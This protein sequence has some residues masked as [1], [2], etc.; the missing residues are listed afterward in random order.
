MPEVQLLSV[1]GSSSSVTC[2]ADLGSCLSVWSAGK[3]AAGAVAIGLHYPDM[4][5]TAHTPC[6]CLF[7]T[8]QTNGDMWFVRYAYG[9]RLGSTQAP[10]HMHLHSTCLPV[11]HAP[12]SAIATFVVTGKPTMYCRV[13]MLFIP[14]VSLLVRLYR[15]YHSG[16]ASAILEFQASVSTS[17]GYDGDE[18]CA[19]DFSSNKLTVT[20]TADAVLCYF[21]F[22][23]T[24]AGSRDASTALA[25]YS[26]APKH[27]M[28]PLTRQLVQIT[29]CCCSIDRVS[30]LATDSH[31]LH[32][33]MCS[34][35]SAVTVNGQQ[36]S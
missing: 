4:I 22:D 2:A 20:I 24:A 35:H 12:R 19:A 33:S 13:S 21:H 7:A 27:S 11:W 18:F 8:W 26:S 31:A 32:V 15:A 17:P 29:C 1:Q 23:S 34:I 25:V 30:H 3:A 14:S 6:D 10:D 16:S 36:M 9:S 28:R 5:F